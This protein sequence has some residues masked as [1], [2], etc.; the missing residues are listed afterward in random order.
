MPMDPCTSNNEVVKA[1]L[2]Y[3]E[4]SYHGGDRSLLYQMWGCRRTFDGGATVPCETGSHLAT[5][6]DAS[7][8][9]SGNVL[10]LLQH[11]SL[12]FR[13]TSPAIV[14]LSTMNLVFHV[15]LSKLMVCKIR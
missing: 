12:H 3:S 10:R 7:K 13:G 2:S 15:L 9:A 14:D 4:T 6:G 11:F 5:G 8:R 1:S